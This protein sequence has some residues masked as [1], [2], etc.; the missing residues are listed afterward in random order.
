MRLGDEIDGNEWKLIE[1][2]VLSLL[3][4]DDVLNFCSKYNLLKECDKYYKYFIET[5]HN[6]RDI[7]VS[8]SEDH[9]IPDYRKLSFILTISDSIENV[10]K[11]ENEFRNKIRKEI[12][13]EK[14]QHF[15]Y[16]YNLT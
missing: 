10:L 3:Y 5:F 1:N 15:V 16:N 2:E 14:R 13:K 7:R 11:H 6:I 4:T 8:V 9:E 12:L